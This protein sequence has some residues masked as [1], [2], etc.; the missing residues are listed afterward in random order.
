MLGLRPSVN[1]STASSAPIDYKVLLTL[2]NDKTNEFT[3]GRQINSLLKQLD[4]VGL[5]AIPPALDM[6]HSINGKTLILPLIKAKTESFDT[7]HKSQQPMH[8]EWQPNEALYNELAELL[9]IIDASYDQHDI[10]EF[11]VYWL[12]KPN[13]HHTQYQ[14]TQ[15][16]ANQ[17]KRNRTT[18][19]YEPTKRI[20]TQA[21][22]VEAGLEADDNTKALVERYATLGQ[23]R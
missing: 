17:I 6:D 8:R 12:G 10:G 22:K 9:G 7:L 14:W 11:V 23:K 3:R 21:V 15:K 13:Q 4:D 18:Q 16:F 19:G 2:L 20:G 5:V 1:M